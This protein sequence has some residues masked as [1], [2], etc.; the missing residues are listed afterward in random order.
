MHCLFFGGGMANFSFLL[1]QYPY[2][3][4]APA[5]LEAE[6]VFKTSPVLCAKGFGVGGQV[7]VL[8]RQI[9]YPAL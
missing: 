4:F 6:K 2:R 8:S 3:S 5:C 9:P 7:G 1:N